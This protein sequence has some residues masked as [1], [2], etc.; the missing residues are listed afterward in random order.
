MEKN[1]VKL[2]V[3]ISIL[4][5]TGFMVTSFVSY[6]VSRTSLRS[7]IALN[8]LPLTSDNIYSE[9]QQDLLRPVF[10]SS[11]MATDTFLRDWV[12][13]GE[14][15][16]RKITKFLK[17]IQTKHNTFTSFFVSDR[18]GLY[19]HADGI[20]KKVSPSEKRDRWYYRVKQ[21]YCSHLLFLQADPG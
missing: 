20:L 10:I 13:Q 21:R 5:V 8:T 3:I 15:D 16:E 2:I 18:T 9:I 1:R 11:L 17:E 7:E 6:F 14:L 19:Y 12:L 4:L